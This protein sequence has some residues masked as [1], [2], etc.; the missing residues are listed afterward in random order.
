MDRIRSHEHPEKAKIVELLS[1]DVSSWSKGMMSTIVELSSKVGSY[2]EMKHML[3]QKEEECMD[4]KAQKK[5]CEKEV[6]YLTNKWHKDKQDFKEEIHQMQRSHLLEIKESE[7]KFRSQI[8]G[9][10]REKEA[11]EKKVLD[12]KVIVDELVEQLKEQNSGAQGNSSSRK[13]LKAKVVELLEILKKTQRELD[14]VKDE[15]S[16][17]TSQLKKYGRS[18]K[19]NFDH[20]YDHS[21]FDR[22]TDRNR[23]YN[24][25][26]HGKLY[27]DDDSFN[28][29]L[30]HEERSP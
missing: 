7:E 19:S 14:K 18:S 28:N 15:N 29:I 2:E 24:H 17:L 13:E 26:T 16:F 21:T 5:Q 3:E 22:G 1:R 9:L 25:V 30:S 12:L 6:K 8:S 11:S 20:G 27:D 4:L 10:K 23:G